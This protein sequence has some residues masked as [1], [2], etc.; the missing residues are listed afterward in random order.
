MSDY[1]ATI[2]REGKWWMVHIPEL[3]GVTQ[4]RRLS[5]AGRMAQEYVAVTLNVPIESVTVNVEVE[6]VGPVK[7]IRARVSSIQTERAQAA[8]LESKA[9]AE[10]TT[11]ARELV[12]ADVPLRDVGAVLGV[13]FQRVH[14][15]V[16]G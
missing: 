15:L 2:T 11:L 9:L 16:A 1:T 3:D 7:N 12:S 8:E 10:T 4:A 14:Q 13:S 6:S 5:E